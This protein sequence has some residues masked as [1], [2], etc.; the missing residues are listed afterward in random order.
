[1]KLPFKSPQAF[2]EYCNTHFA[3]KP[4]VGEGRPA[5]VPPPGFMDIENHVSL[6]DDGRY[7]ASLL[8]CGEPKG[9]FLVAETPNPG[10]DPIKHG[11]LL[12]WK[13]FK[14]PPM[15]GKGSIGRLTG[16]KRSSWIGFIVAKITPEIDETG[17]FTIISRY[18]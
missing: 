14:A 11:D 12:I 6:I 7:R 10:G 17:K 18:Q 2:L 5:L 15:F 16:D 8:V 3:E 4:S 13:A 1:M 9:F